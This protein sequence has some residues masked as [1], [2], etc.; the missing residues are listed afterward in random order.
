MYIIIFI[1]NIVKMGVDICKKNFCIDADYLDSKKQSNNILSTNMIN[2]I[3]NNNSENHQVIDSRNYIT[4]N[5][6]N[7]IIL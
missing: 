1:K 7:I 6:N 5:K 4:I 3:N 2:N